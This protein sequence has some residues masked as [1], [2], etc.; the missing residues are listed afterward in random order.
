M[1]FKY[2]LAVVAIST[3][4]TSHAQT[5]TQQSSGSNS[6]NINGAGSVTVNKDLVVASSPAE[7][8]LVDMAK[9][10]EAA[11]ATYNTLLQ[12][13][14]TN[15][16]TKNKPIL[17]EMKTRSKKWQ[18]KIDAENKDLKAQIT[19]NEVDAADQFKKEVASLSGK[20]V[21]PKTIATLEDIVKKEQNLPATAHFD[22]DQKK[23][24]DMAKK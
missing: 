12:Q 15:L 2:I 21:D 19:K 17:D 18:D 22:V 11:K 10:L 3:A 9:Q 1:K 5:V 16:D 7:D 4:I 13:A 6:P 20:L 24:V 14:R 8:T 23:W